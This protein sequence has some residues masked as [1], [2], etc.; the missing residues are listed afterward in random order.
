MMQS[1]ATVKLYHPVFW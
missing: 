1:G